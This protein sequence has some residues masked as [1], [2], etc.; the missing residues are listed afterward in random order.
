MLPV[1]IETWAIDITQDDPVFEFHHELTEYYGMADLSPAS[2]DLLSERFLADET[3]AVKYLQTMNQMS[4]INVPPV[5]DETCRLGVYCQTRNSVYWDGKRCEGI[6]NDKQW[7]ADPMNA[8]TETL[9]DP[10][11][12]HQRL[13]NEHL[14]KTPIF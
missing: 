9:M 10:W 8:L 12:S 3:L 5:C 4:P 7:K 13:P 2:F 11:Y 1:K 6:E 14:M